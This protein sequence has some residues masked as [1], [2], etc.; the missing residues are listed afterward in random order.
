MLCF[1]PQIYAHVCSNAIN[2]ASLVVLIIY[3]QM[4][5]M[6]KI[7]CLF[8]L[9]NHSQLMKRENPLSL[10][11]SLSWIDISIQST[12]FLWLVTVGSHIWNITNLQEPAKASL[13]GQQNCQNKVWIPIAF[14]S[15]WLVVSIRLNGNNY[16]VIKEF[17][18]RF[19]FL[20]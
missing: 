16:M 17:S 10:S 6:A 9:C 12:T 18:A 19:F 8:I 14:H 13:M 4:I 15:N 11:F 3:T 5:Y 7:V 2:F 20:L 1:T